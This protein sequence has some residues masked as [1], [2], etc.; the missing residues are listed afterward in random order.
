[1]FFV[2]CFYSKQKAPEG[3]HTIQLIQSFLTP[4]IAFITSTEDCP[5]HWLH[6]QQKWE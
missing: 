1:M 5:G 3:A 4:V 2:T 6:E